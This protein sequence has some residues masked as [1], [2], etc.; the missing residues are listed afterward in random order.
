M[1]R[2]F[3]RALS[4]ANAKGIRDNLQQAQDVAASRPIKSNG[5]E[6]SA[7]SPD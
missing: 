1:G 3:S 6:L 4:A 7:A 5:S 2:R